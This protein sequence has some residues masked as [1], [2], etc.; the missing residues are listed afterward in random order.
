MVYQLFATTVLAPSQLLSMRPPHL[1]I[2]VEVYLVLD[3]LLLLPDHV[4]LDLVSA[5]VD[6]RCIQRVSVSYLQPLSLLLQKD[7]VILKDLQARQAVKVITQ[8]T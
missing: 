7:R 4:I 5:I 6:D 1:G 2:V 3:S 8:S